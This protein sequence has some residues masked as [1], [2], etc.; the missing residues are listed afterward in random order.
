MTLFPSVPSPGL[1]H[2]DTTAAMAHTLHT[3]AKDADALKLCICAALGNTDLDVSVV[4]G[5]SVPNKLEVPLPSLGCPVL[6]TASGTVIQD[7]NSAAVFLGEFFL[8]NCCMFEH[9]A[10]RL[11]LVATHM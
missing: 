8:L 11:L 1:T 3:T 10:C 7:V 2:V 6:S 9:L 5:T 4:S